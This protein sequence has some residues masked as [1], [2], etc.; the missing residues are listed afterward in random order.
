M[1]KRKTSK[2]LLQ[3]YLK[4]ANEVYLAFTVADLITKAEKVLENETEVREQ[5][6]NSMITPD[7][8]INYNKELLKYFNQ[9]E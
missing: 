1:A 5:M 3:N 9:G 8:W 2:Q 6:K 4:N 7:L